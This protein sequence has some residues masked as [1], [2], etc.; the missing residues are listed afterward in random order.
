[1]EL[2]IQ[3]VQDRWIIIIAAIIG[4]IIIMKLVKSLIKWIIIIAIAA[5][6]IMYGSNYNW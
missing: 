2:L 3:F 5:A 6:L 4:I 1:M